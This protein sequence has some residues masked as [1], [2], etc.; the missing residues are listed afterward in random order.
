MNYVFGRVPHKARV[1]PSDRNSDFGTSELDIAVAYMRAT[2][3]H[4]TVSSIFEEAHVVA[5]PDAA[6]LREALSRLPEGAFVVY[7]D[8]AASSRY[9]CRSQK[10]DART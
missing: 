8:L 4:D 6:D 9:V 3:R 10:T 5:V 1:V 2:I 7:C